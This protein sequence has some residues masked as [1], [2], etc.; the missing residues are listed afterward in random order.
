MADQPTDPTSPPKAY[1]F[2]S[3]AIPVPPG[4]KF[5]GKH[6]VPLEEAAPEQSWLI[7]ATMATVA[8]II[9]VL[10]GRFLIP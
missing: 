7:P 8:L 2:K 4:T 6:L 3:K 1:V 10:I 5:K 9:G